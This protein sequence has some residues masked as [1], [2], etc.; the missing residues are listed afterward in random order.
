MVQRSLTAKLRSDVDKDG[1]ETITWW[2]PA[3]SIAHGVRV[4][5]Q[6]A[7][8]WDGD[9]MMPTIRPSVLSRTGSIT[10]HCHVLLGMLL[11]LT[12]STHA[13]AG[14]TVPVP[15]WPDISTQDEFT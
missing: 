5:G 3:C 7:W 8:D 13:L 11:F 2:C 14:Q 6:N 4:D 10:C 12:D 9:V 15:D 1:N